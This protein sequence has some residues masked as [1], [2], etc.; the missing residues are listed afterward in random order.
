MVPEHIPSISQ[1]TEIVGF[2]RSNI[3]EYISKA[4]PDATERG[5]FFE[6]LST[7]PHIRSTMYV[8]LNCA[9]V[10]DVYRF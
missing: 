3:N 7:Y 4:F 5:K 9:V 8:P 6:Y 10:V 2:T 1:Y